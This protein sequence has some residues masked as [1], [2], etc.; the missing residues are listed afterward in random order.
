MRPTKQPDSTAAAPDPATLAAARLAEIK[1][2]QRA[3][4]QRDKRLLARQLELDAVGTIPD[5]G[6]GEDSAR[7]V[8]AK[9]INGFAGADFSRTTLPREL[10]EIIRERYAIQI[11]LAASHQAEHQARS[12]MTAHVVKERSGAWE[13]AL[14]ETFEAL[15]ALQAVNRRREALAR[16]IAELCGTSVVMLG[17]RGGASVG[18][19]LRQDILKFCAGDFVDQVVALGLVSRADVERMSEE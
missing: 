7:S 11:A 18:D 10:F 15:A 17:L 14:M 5:A 12:E 19:F 3:W 2:K 1:A 8:A 16:Q 6:D 13:A 9:L 4:H